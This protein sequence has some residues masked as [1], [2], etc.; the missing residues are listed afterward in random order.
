MNPFY[1]QL[2]CL[3]STFYCGYNALTLYIS[4]DSFAMHRSHIHRVSKI[5]CIF[6]FVRISSNLHQFS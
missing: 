3:L 1:K 6:V 2:Q 4:T 5:L